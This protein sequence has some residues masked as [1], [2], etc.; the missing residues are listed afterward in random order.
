ML[1][2]GC[3]PFRRLMSG[4]SNGGRPLPILAL[5][6]PDHASLVDQQDIALANPRANLLPTAGLG[7]QR[8]VLD[9]ET[10][11]QP[12]RCLARQGCTMNPIVLKFTGHARPAASTADLPSPPN[13]TNAALISGDVLDPPG[14]VHPRAALKCHRSSSGSPRSGALARRRSDNDARPHL[15]CHVSIHN[16]IA[17]LF[18]IPSNRHR[19]LRAE[20]MSLWPKIESPPWNAVSAMQA[21]V[22]NTSE[23]VTEA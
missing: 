8:E 13:P 15:Q 14:A 16:P 10:L 5:A 12:F 9:A 21:F 2:I 7:G 6:A 18:D 23:Q 3:Q 17:N 11:L 20:A 1:P 19:Q 22:T 4:K